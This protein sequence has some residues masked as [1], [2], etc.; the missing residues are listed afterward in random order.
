MFRDDS[1]DSSGNYELFSTPILALQE[2]LLA[3]YDSNT[4]KK[5]Q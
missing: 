2:K 5:E 3:S 1:Q 4:P